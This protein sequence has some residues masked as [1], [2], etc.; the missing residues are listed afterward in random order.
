[1]YKRFFIQLE[2]HAA[3][4]L[5]RVYEGGQNSTP[6]YDMKESYPDGEAASTGWYMTSK[7]LRELSDNLWN[8][9]NTIDA[10]EAEREDMGFYDDDFDPWYEDEMFDETS[11][12]F[13]EDYADHAPGYEDFG[14]PFDDDPSA[15]YTAVVEG[16]EVLIVA[17]GEEVVLI[18]DPLQA[19]ELLLSLDDAVSFL[20]QDVSSV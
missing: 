1:V 6:I 14:F 5:R 7:S 20:M 3:W 9:A 17:D 13:W 11:E 4:S 19:E 18:L 10:E 12:E 15:E 8:I 2:N 16:D